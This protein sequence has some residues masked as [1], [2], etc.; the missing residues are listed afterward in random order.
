MEKKKKN[1]ENIRENLYNLREGKCFVDKKQNHGENGKINNFEIRIYISFESVTLYQQNHPMCFTGVKSCMNYSV[2][3]SDVHQFSWFCPSGHLVGLHVP[4]SLH[5]QVA[6][7]S[8]ICFGQ[9]NVSRADLCHSGQKPLRAREQ[10]AMFLSLRHGGQPYF[11]KGR[12][13]SEDD[14]DQNLPLTQDG[15]GT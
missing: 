13:L 10:T 6:E 7:L 1:T 2:F 12:F 4:S 11:T 8:V 5:F 14:R 15:H 9:G 3:N